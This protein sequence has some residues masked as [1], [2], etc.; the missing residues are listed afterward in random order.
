MNKIKFK[1]KTN[2]QTNVRQ[3]VKKQN[4][5]FSIISKHKLYLRLFGTLREFSKFSP[6][7]VLS[8]DRRETL[9]AIDCTF[10]IVTVDLEALCSD[11]E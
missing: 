8:F 5:T 1:K 3:K 2:K 9:T 4:K 6:N 7:T 11:V 10:V